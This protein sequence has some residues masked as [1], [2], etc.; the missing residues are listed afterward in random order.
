MVVAAMA[1]IGF[2]EAVTGDREQGWARGAGVSVTCEMIGAAVFSSISQNYDPQGRT[3]AH[4][5][6][7]P[8]IIVHEESR[9]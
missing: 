8:I 5:Q 7:H 9:F 4:E 1:G 6:F 2:G 3:T